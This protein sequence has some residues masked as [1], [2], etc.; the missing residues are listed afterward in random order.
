M[1]DN[2]LEYILFGLYL[3]L[4]VTVWILFLIGM[5]A[6]RK[7]MS[8]LNRPA[9]KPP[10]P[11]PKATILIPAKDEGGRIADCIRSACAQTYPNYEVIAVNDRSTDQTGA[12]MDELA[13][14]LPNLRVRHIR[15]DELPAG[16][17]GKCNALYRTVNEAHGDWLLFIDSDVVIT[18]DAL[19]AALSRAA[20]RGYDLM[21]LWPK[22]ESYSFSEKLLVPLCAAGVSMMY[23]VSLTN[24]DYMK[25]VAFANGQFLLIKRSVYDEMGGHA[26]V[27]DRFCEDVEM[28]RLLKR[29]GKRIRIAWG[30]DFA[31]VRMYSSL[32][33]IFKG[34]GR[35]FYAASLGKPWRIL[36]AIAF[37]V[38]CGFSAYAAAAWTIFRFINPGT[39]WGGPWGWLAAAVTHLILMHLSL[40]KL[41]TWSGNPGTNAG[42]FPLGG[43]ML[44]GVFI[45]SL[46]MCATGKVEWRGTHYTH[47]MPHTSAAAVDGAATPTPTPTPGE[48]YHEH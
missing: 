19:Q 35:N 41:Y 11:A 16:W 33:G 21:S 38:L 18:P 25:N 22:L 44:I 48:N 15:E 14:E 5:Y 42:L 32:S 4:G 36:L 40:A 37:V 13:K 1:P 10:Q 24:K 8:L 31:A 29:R 26:A 6:G 9:P 27:K 45:K 46:R 20:R 30:T 28:A 7:R 17:T 3:L 47:L 34:W 39:V 23:L 43:S 2:L 12:I